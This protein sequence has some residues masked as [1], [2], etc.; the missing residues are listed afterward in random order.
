MAV[1]A[2]RWRRR[3]SQTSTTA[4]GVGGSAVDTDTSPREN[5]NAP[6]PMTTN[7]AFRG[8]DDAIPAAVYA[9]LE[10]PDSRGVTGK[11]A[12]VYDRAGAS[13]A[14]PYE[15]PD[16]EPE[17]N[18]TG[19]QP[20]Y[21]EAKD[22]VEILATEPNSVVGLHN[23]TMYAV[24]GQ[25]TQQM[26]LAAGVGVGQAA[27]DYATLGANSGAD[28]GAA[29]ASAAGTYAELVPVAASLPPAAYATLDAEAAAGVRCPPASVDYA[30][31]QQDGG[32]PDDGNANDHDEGNGYTYATV[33]P[34][35]T[36]TSAEPDV[37]L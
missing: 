28:R 37:D 35:A 26:D 19:P 10:G 20:E 22:D 30:Q 34:P 31:P 17:S 25:M 13:T 9:K 36:S 24:A 23:N 3:A 4:P 1:G 14:A 6:A 7:A 15:D 18:N 32:S 21:A 33:P 8:P 2:V 29:S 5:N 16:A 27:A 11:P 12:G